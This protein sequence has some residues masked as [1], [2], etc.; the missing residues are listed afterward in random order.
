MTSRL[1]GARGTSL[2]RYS[3]ALVLLAITIADCGP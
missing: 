3:P 2:F 1:D